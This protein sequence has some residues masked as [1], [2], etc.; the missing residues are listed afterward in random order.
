MAA[1]VVV[2]LVA[3]VVVV[4]VVVMDTHI[5]THPTPTHTHT[6]PTP[7][8]THTLPT[9]PHTH[10]LPPFTSVVQARQSGFPGTLDLSSCLRPLKLKARK[11]PLL[12]TVTNVSV[13]PVRRGIVARE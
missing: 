2:V 11:S 5:H 12:P 8:H 10:T 6:L 4:V 7:P 3:V 13:S 9:P 1:V